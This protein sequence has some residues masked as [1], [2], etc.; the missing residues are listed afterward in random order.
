MFVY[1]KNVA[2]DL[3]NGDNYIKEAFLQ[4][5][6]GDK[7]IIDLL[8]TKNIPT[9]RTQVTPKD[10]PPNFILP[11]STPIVT[12]NDRIRTE[13][14]IVLPKNRLS[15]QF[16]LRFFIVGKISQYFTDTKR[17]STVP[18]KWISAVST[19]PI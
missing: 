11:R 10:T 9:K 14:A 6:F 19:K 2:R 15:N 3:L 7:E 13:W 17:N 1:G 16:I 18:R 4:D 12:T 5:N 8:K